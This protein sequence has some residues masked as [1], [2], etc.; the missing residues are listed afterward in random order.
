MIVNIKSKKKGCILFLL[1][2]TIVLRISAESLKDFRIIQKDKSSTKAH[3]FL[4]FSGFCGD[5]LKTLQRANIM[6]SKTIRDQGKGRYEISAEESQSFIPSPLTSKA[7]GKAITL[8][9]ASVTE[10]WGCSPSLRF[11]SRYPST[12]VAALNLIYNPLLKFK[13]VLDEL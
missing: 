10:P 9:S 12:R 5:F 8:T 4:T 13:E 6:P 1:R 2:T 7:L 3:C 11:F